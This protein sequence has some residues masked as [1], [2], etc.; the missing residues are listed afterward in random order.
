MKVILDENHNLRRKLN[1]ADNMDID[2]QQTK[3]EI[4]QDDLNHVEG[5]MYF[6]RRI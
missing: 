2:A 6:M 4:K 5:E 1:T 3:L